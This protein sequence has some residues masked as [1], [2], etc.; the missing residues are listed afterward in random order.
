[1]T[2]ETQDQGVCVTNKPSSEVDQI[3]HHRLEPTALFGPP[4]LLAG[5]QPDLTD[6]PQDVVDQ[7]GTANQRQKSLG[8]A[9]PSLYVKTGSCT[10]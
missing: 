5:H 8:M 1:M 10:G 7:S 4:A 2:A 6:G 9:P 3:L